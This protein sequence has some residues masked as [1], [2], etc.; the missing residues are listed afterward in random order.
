M[1]SD[2]HA[3]TA[4]SAALLF[5]KAVSPIT[6]SKSNIAFEIKLPIMIAPA[7]NSQLK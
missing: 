1:P 7:S 2:S 4:I 5:I 6:K 3:S